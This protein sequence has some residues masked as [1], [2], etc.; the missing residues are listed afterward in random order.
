MPE[1]WWYKSVMA[2]GTKIISVLGG[3]GPAATAD[4]YQKLIHATLGARR[5]P[6]SCAMETF[7]FRSSTP[8][9]ASP[10][11]R[12]GAHSPRIPNSPPGGR[13]IKTG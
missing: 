6:S 10:A 8:P 2:T 11:P 3:T 13:V 12:C 5:S 4:F 9:G 1:L 7:R